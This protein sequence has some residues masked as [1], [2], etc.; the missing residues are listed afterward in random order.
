MKKWILAKLM[1]NWLGEWD[2]DWER[3]SR[4]GGQIGVG[5]SPSDY[6]AG[7]ASRLAPVILLS[8]LLA[9][10]S[11]LMKLVLPKLLSQLRFRIASIQVRLKVLSK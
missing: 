9:T 11:M 1:S 2:C 5:L 8:S 3:F 6:L 4:I 10:V 7:Q